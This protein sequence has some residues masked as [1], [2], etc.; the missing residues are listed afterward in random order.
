MLVKYKFAPGV[1][2]EG[3]EYTADS[4]WFDSDKIR[5]RKGRPEQIGG[6]QKYSSNTFLGICRSLHDWKAAAATDY[7]GLGTTLKYYVNRGDAYYDITPIRVTTAAGDV[8]FAAVNGDATLTVSDTGHGAQQNDFV[9]FSGAVS[10]GGNISAAVLNQE[11]QVATV[12]DGNSY[13]IEAKDTAGSEV[14]AN[15]S[16]TGNGGSSIVGVYQINTGLDT[17]VPSTNR[18]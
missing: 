4:G 6:W 15:A 1:N 17:F 16:D 2:K 5:F 13:T 12:I 9:T 11:Y 10:L 3:T 14:V 8:T 18:S 7:L